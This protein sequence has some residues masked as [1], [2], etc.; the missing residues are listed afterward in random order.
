MCGSEALALGRIR[1]MHPMYMC[2]FQDQNGGKRGGR[3]EGKIKGEETFKK[4]DLNI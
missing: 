3:G 4:K 1:K 2:M